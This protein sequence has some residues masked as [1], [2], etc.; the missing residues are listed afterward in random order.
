MYLYNKNNNSEKFLE[1]VLELVLE[2]FQ[3]VY[4]VILIVLC[5]VVIE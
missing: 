4:A 2:D 1:L 5:S 3:L